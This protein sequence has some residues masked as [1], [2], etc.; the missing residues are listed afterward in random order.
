MAADETR[1]ERLRRLIAERRARP[2]DPAHTRD[3]PADPGLPQ[4]GDDDDK[5]VAIHHAPKDTPD[6]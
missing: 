3:L 4:P 6:L 5:T 2:P 1:A